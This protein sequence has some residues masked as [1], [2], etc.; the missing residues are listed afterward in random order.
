MMVNPLLV[1][2][3]GSASLCPC[4]FL[5]TS[6]V[7][8]YCCMWICV[9]RSAG[10]A[11]RSSSG[12]VL[13]SALITSVVHNLIFSVYCQSGNGSHSAV[14]WSKRMILAKSCVN[15]STVHVTLITATCFSN[16]AV[17]PSLGVRPSVCPSVCL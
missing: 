12:N 8:S 2:V 15:P 16:V 7:S 14:K 9:G 6:C 13:V 11:S 1:S 3:S 17:M 10:F 4:L 5:V